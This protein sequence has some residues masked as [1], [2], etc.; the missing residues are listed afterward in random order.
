MLESLLLVLVPISTFY[1]TV[2]ILQ[3]VAA[4]RQARKK[5]DP[6]S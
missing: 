2:W 5:A 6:E 4:R 1:A 3:Q